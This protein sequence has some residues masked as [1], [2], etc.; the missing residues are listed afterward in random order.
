MKAKTTK[1]KEPTKAESKQP[2]NGEVNRVIKAMILA[3]DDAQLASDELLGEMSYFDNF[4]A[5]WYVFMASQYG[6]VF[7]DITEL[8]HA[9]GEVAKA[10]NDLFT[11]YLCKVTE[12]EPPKV[13]E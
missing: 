10:W 1:A 2:T 6:F 9:Y 3:R 13:P 7:N 12:P 11:Q 5:D 4:D 8:E